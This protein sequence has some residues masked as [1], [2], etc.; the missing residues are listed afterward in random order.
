MKNPLHYQV[1][2]YD[3]GPTS[4]INAVSYLFDRESLP[5]EIVRN[6]MLYCLDCH[7]SDGIPGKMG[8]SCSA[9][10]FLSSWL[11][12]FGKL[13]LLPISSSYISDKKVYIGQNSL[14]NDTLVRG[15]AV[16]ARLFYDE[17]HYVLITGIEND[18]LLL[19]DPYYREEPFEE[20]EDIKIVTDHP[21]S[22]NR[23]V[24]ISCFNCEEEKLYAFGGFD[25]REA[26]LIFNNDTKLTQ[27][28][29]V[30]YFI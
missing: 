23:I 13:D 18:N 14:I 21:F 20:N 30:E 19:F 16:V 29:T 26:V 28:D 1:T 2:N 11:D 24:P 4:M 12:G 7:S 6:I 3:C 9:M 27:E 8:T 15:G 17:W 5:P 25:M 10:M 22:Y